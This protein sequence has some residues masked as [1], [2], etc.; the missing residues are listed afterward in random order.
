MRKEDKIQE[1]LIFEKKRNENSINVDF[2]DKIRENL[3]C[4]HASSSSVLRNSLPSLEVMQ[5]N[6]NNCTTKKQLL[7]NRIVIVLEECENKR[8]KILEMRFRIGV[9]NSKRQNLISQTEQLRMH[10]SNLA[11]KKEKGM[12]S[13]LQRRW[14]FVF[15]KRIFVFFFFL[16]FLLSLK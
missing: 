7:Q 16:F 13:Q 8:K 5:I 12:V 10:R 15:E 1:L 4:H 14:I 2:L 3:L 6:K 11:M 9:L